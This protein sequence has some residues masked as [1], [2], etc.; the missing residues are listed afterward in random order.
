MI[1]GVSDTRR[2]F[3][4][5]NGRRQGVV[6]GSTGTFTAE[7]VSILAKAINVTGNFTQWQ[8]VNPGLAIPFEKGAL[9][10]YYPAQEYIWALSPEKDRQKYI[11]S[12]MAQPRKSVLLKGALTHAVS[13]SVSGAPSTSTKRGGFLG[14][15]FYEQDFFYGFAFDIGAR[16]ER[17]AI[18]SSGVS[19][20]T[21]RALVIA[22][23]IKYFNNF[24][25]VL[26]G[27]R[28]YMGIGAG[29]GISN[30]STTGLSQSGVV[31]ILPTV[32]AG[33]ALP[34]NEDWEFL[35]DTAFESLQTKE[36]QQGGQYQTTTQTN[37]KGSIAL[38][39]SFKT[40]T[41][42]KKPPEGGFYFKLI[43]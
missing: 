32:K 43:F 42:I 5:R 7:D 36:Q 2:T 21:K 26:N 25:D 35:F 16:Y 10:T 31:G 28:L 29:Y 11:K 22:D 8:V 17:E 27:G 38:R 4:T 18:T 3:I 13:E 15:A 34:F 12:M 33:I 24:E 23:L 6:P 30:T 9:V 20:L 39:K 19:L 41:R 40:T 14:E 37:L 1:Q